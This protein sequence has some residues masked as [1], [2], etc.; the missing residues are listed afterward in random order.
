MDDDADDTLDIPA[1][2][3]ADDSI[4]SDSLDAEADDAD[5]D[6]TPIETLAQLADAMDTPVG[7]LVAN[8]SHSFKAAGEDVTVT[9]AELES[10][11]QKDADYRRSTAKL[12]TDRRDFDVDIGNRMQA[13]DAQNAGLSHAMTVAEQIIGAEL[14]TD[15]MKTM[16]EE[17]PAEWSA[18]RDEIG[19]RLTYIRQARDQAAG[20]YTTYVQGSRTELRNRELA[21]LGESGD[22]GENERTTVRSVMNDMG[23]TDAELSQ[24]TDSRLVRGVLELHSL[25]NEVR[26][27]RA[28]KADAQDTAKRIKRDVPK[29]QKP[30]KQVSRQARGKKLDR[31][32]ANQLRGRLKKS[33]KVED[34]AAV[35]ESMNII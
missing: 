30:G 10:G 23:F 6:D 14:N 1:A 22:W 15:R 33:G 26:D 21:S 19:A 20:A 32:R 28:Q 31:T 5:T 8:L 4:E 11:Y 25:R 34:A 3:T 18:R 7:D 27:L 2:D 29:M 24:V 17:D 13:F 16:R 12:A 35:I 9:L